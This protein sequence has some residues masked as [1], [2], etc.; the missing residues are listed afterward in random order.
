[1]TQTADDRQLTRALHHYFG[2]DHF[3]DGQLA[4]LR[5]IMAGQDTLAVLP[6]GAGKT[7][8]Y[9]LPAYLTNRL[10][11]VVSPL[12]SLMQDQVDRLHARGEKRVVML[13][14]QLSGHA[15]TVVLKNLGAYRFVFASPEILVN[16][17]VL[18]SVRRA[19][20]GFL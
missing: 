9:Q 20:P 6:T 19:H 14:S 8:L 5:S 4:V 13:S 12:I 10:V 17:R 11:V 18:S 16:P 7:L 15:R 3:R 2:Y 1:M